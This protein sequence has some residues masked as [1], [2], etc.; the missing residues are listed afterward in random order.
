MKIPKFMKKAI[1]LLVLM[2]VLTGCYIEPEGDTV[3]IS[4][5]PD[6]FVNNT[7]NNTIINNTIE[8]PIITNSTI[9]NS[10]TSK[11]KTKTKELTN[12]AYIDDKGNMYLE[13][14]D[15]EIV[16]PEMKETGYYENKGYYDAIFLFSDQKIGIGVCLPE[17][18]GEKDMRYIV[19]DDRNER[20]NLYE[21]YYE[22]GLN[23]WIQYVEGSSELEE[24]RMIKF[25]LTQLVAKVLHNNNYNYEIIVDPKYYLPLKIIKDKSVLF[26]NTQRIQ[27]FFLSESDEKKYRKLGDHVLK[28]LEGNKLGEITK[29]ELITPIDIKNIEIYE[30]EHALDHSE[31]VVLKAIEFNIENS[32]DKNIIGNLKIKIVSKDS[33]LIYDENIRLEKKEKKDMILFFDKYIEFTEIYEIKLIFEYDDSTTGITTISLDKDD[34]IDIGLIKNTLESFLNI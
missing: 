28:T 8:S 2:V 15:F 33:D 13:F 3:I 31:K 12:L 23:N 21:K 24:T 4:N 29:H 20:R 34:Y 5:D 32:F 27:Y 11:I 1:V 18:S 25:S 6:T 16:I 22:N 19:C 17:Y 7:L 9:M 10:S 26:S 14:W 30:Y